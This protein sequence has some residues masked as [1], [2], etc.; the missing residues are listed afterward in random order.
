MNRISIPR[1]AYII[2]GIACLLLLATAKASNTLKPFILAKTLP[3]TLQAATEQT[4]QA[5]QKAGF[6]LV[7]Q[8]S[9]YP[10]ATILIVTND[11]LLHNAVNSPNGGFGAAIRVSL[12]RVNNEVQLS[13]NNPDYIANVYRMPDALTDVTHELANALG[14]MQEYGSEK[15]LS[16]ED[17]RDYHYAFMM[18]YFTDT[19]KLAEY[20]DQ[21]TALQKIN[22]ILV[23]KKTGVNK[24][25]QIDLPGKDVTVI[26]VQLTGK[27]GN[28]CSGDQYI[29]S[30]IDFKQLK[31]TGHLPY[32]IMINQGKVYTLPAEFRIAINFPDLSMMGSNSFASIMCAP[33]AIESALTRATGGK[34]EDEEF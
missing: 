3:M 12:T 16:K 20:R 2:I 8:Y 17:L 33:G 4:A 24:V 34:T 5:L 6:R 1:S 32:E 22:T 9:P 18:P 13:Y 21:T 7:G 14:L 15:G 27:I 29:M 28:E 26:G 10:D 23:N 30:R 19:L 11:K 31:S 25:Y